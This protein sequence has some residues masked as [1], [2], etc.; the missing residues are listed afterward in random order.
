MARDSNIEYVLQPPSKLFH[1]TS[2]NITALGQF[3]G[4]KI[5]R[6]NI[7]GVNGGQ[8]II[9]LYTGSQRGPVPDN[10]TAVI[11]TLWIGSNIFLPL[12]NSTSPH[13][14]ANQRSG[15]QRVRLSQLLCSI[16]MFSIT[17]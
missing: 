4:M 10:I 2:V 14:L 3:K 1:I 8:L 5:S 17:I 12:T 9:S 13:T 16:E 6:H 7:L 15:S 11:A